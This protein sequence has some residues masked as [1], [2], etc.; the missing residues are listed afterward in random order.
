MHT[1]CSQLGHFYLKIIWRDGCP[2]GKKIEIFF[3]FGLSSYKKERKEKKRFNM[4]YYKMENL[5]FLEKNKLFFLF[6]VKNVNFFF[7]FSD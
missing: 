2:Q 4:I 6:K 1:I 7:L 3:E 5:G